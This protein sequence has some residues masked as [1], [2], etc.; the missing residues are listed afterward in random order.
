M[1]FSFGDP[2]QIAR[3]YIESTADI[4][5]P[6]I[7]EGHYEE[8]EDWQIRCQI[9]YLRAALWRAL[10]ERADVAVIEV[11]DNSYIQIVLYYASINPK[12]REACLKN[13]IQYPGGSH[14]RKLFRQALTEGSAN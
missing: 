8:L 2:D 1:S 3:L 5:G 13:K 10:R 9:T 7:P 14:H 11:L 4:G 12:F 6:G